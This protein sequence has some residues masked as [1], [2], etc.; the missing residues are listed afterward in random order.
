[1]R[2]LKLNK[3]QFVVFNDG[4]QFQILTGDEG[5]DNEEDFDVEVNKLFLKYDC[6]IVNEDNYI[7]GQKGRKRHLIAQHS[8]KAFH[9]ALKV[10]DDEGY[11]D[12]FYSWTAL[13]DDDN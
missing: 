5:F 6:I 1:M 11:E 4:D 3:Q 12:F 7:Y 8:F 10:I 13:I 9:I 2:E